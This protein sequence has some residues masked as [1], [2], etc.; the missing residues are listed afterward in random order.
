MEAAGRGSQTAARQAGMAD[1]D[2]SP[3]TNAV[4]VAG[5]A[6]LNIPGSALVQSLAPLVGRVSTPEPVRDEIGRI[7]L[8]RDQQEL[9]NMSN[10]IRAINEARRRQAQ[11]AGRVGGVAGMQSAQ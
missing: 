8:S 3:I 11:A 7:L 2:V 5:S 9:L 6:G 10:T 1:L 4:G